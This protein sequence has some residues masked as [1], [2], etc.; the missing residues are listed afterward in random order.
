MLELHKQATT[1]VS[2]SLMNKA[3]MAAAADR[4]P[5]A[6]RKVG[7]PRLY[8]GTQVATNPPTLLLFVNNPS[9][10]DE[11]Y[12]RYLVNRLRDL[13]PFSEVPIRLLLRSHH[14]KAIG[15]AQGTDRIRQNG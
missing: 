5:S 2:T 15:P 8:Y 4:A 1:T 12:Q 11:N 3:L 13:L 10:F 9:A 6:R 7:L 14:T